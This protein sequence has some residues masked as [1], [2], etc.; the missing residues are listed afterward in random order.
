MTQIIYVSPL[1]ILKNV[2]AVEELAGNAK[3]LSPPLYWEARFPLGELHL[4]DLEVYGATSWPGTA[5]YWKYQLSI[6][7]AG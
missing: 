6:D 3:A 1:N 7:H 4:C 2:M 5:H